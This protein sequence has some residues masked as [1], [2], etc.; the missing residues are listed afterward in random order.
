MINETPLTGDCTDW[1]RKDFLRQYNCTEELLQCSGGPLYSLAIALELS[2]VNNS[3]GKQKNLLHSSPG[4][5][6]NTEIKVSTIFPVYKQPK[7]QEL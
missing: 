4:C 1:E 7:V 6:I 5:F 3:N 2:S